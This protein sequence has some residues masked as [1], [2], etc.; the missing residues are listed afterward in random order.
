MTSS[1]KAE[2]HHQM[3]TEP[4]PQGI[5]APR[6][7]V[8]IGPA[9]PEIR[10]QTDI[11]TDCYTPLPYRDGVKILSV[12]YYRLE[13][14]FCHIC[15]LVWRYGKNH[16]SCVQSH[17]LGL[18]YINNVFV[19]VALPRTLV[20]KLPALPKPPHWTWLPVLGSEGKRGD[21]KR[22]GRQ[23]KGQLDRGWGGNGRG[24]GRKMVGLA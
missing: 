5:C 10:S 6:N 24:I 22:L 16:F 1:I 20:A 7:F 4:R 11:Q 19:A 17:L 23:G 8:K 3:R 21:K 9:V 18:I 12:Y 14:V 15:L 13:W 2:V